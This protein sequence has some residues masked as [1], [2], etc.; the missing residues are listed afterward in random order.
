MLIEDLFE[1]SKAS[2]KSVTLQIVDVDICNLLRQAYL[3][4]DDRISSAGLDFKFNLP[5]EKIILPL[6]SQKTYRIFDNLY[7]NIV[8]YA[9]SGTR[10]YVLLKNEAEY[11]KIELKNISATELSMA[12][13]E[14]TERFVRGDDARNTEG[15]GL[16]LAIAKSFAEL[17]GG[18]M[19]IDIDGDLFKVTLRF[20]K[21]VRIS[22]PPQIVPVYRLKQW[23]SETILKPC[24]S[25]RTG[26]F[27]ETTA[28]RPCRATVR[29]PAV[30]RVDTAD[31]NT[32]AAVRG[33]R[34]TR[35][36]ALGLPI[37]TATTVIREI[38]RAVRRFPIRP[39]SPTWNGR[40]R[41]PPIPGKTGTRLRV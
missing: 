37:P 5:D 36:E 27:R 17:Q 16:G 13:E 39:M 8:K 34:E 6:D 11:V 41:V 31:R 23:C 30:R 22:R 26:L 21:K 2:S 40:I 33:C 35:A 25:R 4:Q 12:A 28:I 20:K 24:S 32:M 15:S 14:L 19:K 7:S 38:I 1:I 10:V 29:R 9:L 18:S 3:E